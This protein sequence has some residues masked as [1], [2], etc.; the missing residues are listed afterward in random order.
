[1]KFL[2]T[3]AAIAAIALASPVFAQAAGGAGQG[4]NA[5]GSA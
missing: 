4:S 3:T 1:M 5:G 2:L